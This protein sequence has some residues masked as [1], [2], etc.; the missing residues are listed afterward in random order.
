LSLIAP[1]RLHWIDDNSDELL[2]YGIPNYTSKWWWN[3]LLGPEE[4]GDDDLGTVEAIAKCYGRE[5]FMIRGHSIFSTL[6][7]HCRRLL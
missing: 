3:D 2:L 7:E 5:K 1:Q 4:A 6:K